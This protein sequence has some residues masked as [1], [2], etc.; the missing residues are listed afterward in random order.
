MKVEWKTYEHEEWVEAPVLQR[1]Y[2]TTY[3]NKNYLIWLIWIQTGCWIQLEEEEESEE[4]GFRPLGRFSVQK[5]PWEW[6]RRNRDHLLT[7][8]EDLMV[9]P[10]DLMVKELE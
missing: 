2:E 6:L 5:Q 4:N 1:L 9:S 3:H 10:L 8:A 7:W